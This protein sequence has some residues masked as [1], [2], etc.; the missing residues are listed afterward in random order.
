[1]LTERQVNQHNR[2]YELRND[3]IQ[4]KDPFSGE[5]LRGDKPPLSLE[6][7][8]GLAMGY[9]FLRSRPDITFTIYGETHGD[10][11]YSDPSEVY[12]HLAASDIVF[13][14]GFG[15]TREVESLF[16]NVCTRGETARVSPTTFAS[17][18]DYMKRQLQL[19]A[20][21]GK[22][23]MLPEIPAGGSQ[24]EN[25]L[26]SFNDIMHDLLPAALGG[27]QDFALAV[28]INLVAGTMLREWY[29][30]G[31][32]GLLI[33]AYEQSTGE[34]LTSPMVWIGQA[35]L[36]TMP[37]KFESLGVGVTN[38]AAQRQSRNTPPRPIVGEYERTN[39]KVPFVEAARDGLARLV[40]H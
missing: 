7:D 14:E 9:D 20:G 32:M 10:S 13:L 40:R 8:T 12:E 24:L 22:P 23:V 34:H 21:T 28:E 16:W 30:I 11:D 5:P 25:D 31:K 37:R 36:E 35:H 29:M 3:I 17:M 27:D 39:G 2:S 26:L 38:Y 33:Q 6:R 1:M 18:S 15:S 4:L 19:M